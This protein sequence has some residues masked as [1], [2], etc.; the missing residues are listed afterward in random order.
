MV[1]SSEIVNKSLQN[2]LLIGVFTILPL[3]LGLIINLLY[4]S[5]TIF[6]AK[7]EFFIYGVALLSSSILSHQN[8]DKIKTLLKGW[9][10]VVSFVLIV[11]FASAYAI[12][13][14]IPETPDI[15]KMKWI[16]ITIII[17]SIIIFYISQ[18]MFVKNELI[19]KEQLDN[20]DVGEVR[21]EEQDDITGKLK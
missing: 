17:V 15:T 16:S 3:L 18:H 11:L 21:Y 12:T 7:G 9:I 5:E 4:S 2:T 14:S 1:S 19:K 13:T 10:N 6:Y 8:L 20:S